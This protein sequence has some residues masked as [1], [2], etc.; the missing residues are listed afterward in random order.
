MQESLKVHFL[1]TSLPA[2]GQKG[3]SIDHESKETN[4]LKVLSDA[5]NLKQPELKRHRTNTSRTDQS[6]G[7][8]TVAKKQPKRRNYVHCPITTPELTPTESYPAQQLAAGSDR[9]GTQ[10]LR[11]RQKGETELEEVLYK[12]VVFNPSAIA[13]F[14]VSEHE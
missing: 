5:R 3:K 13:G 1:T 14:I 2:G 9:E 10:T 7:I 4:A 8:E 6:E 12:I 11:D